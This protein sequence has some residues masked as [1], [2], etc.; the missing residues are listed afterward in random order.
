MDP[1]LIQLNLRRNTE[2]L[3]DYLRDLNNWEEE[4][5]HKDKLLTEQKPILKKVSYVIFSAVEKCNNVSIHAHDFLAEVAA[6]AK[7]ENQSRRG[8]E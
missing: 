4:I 2:D 8:E 1:N 5:K 7:Q 6:S 3:Q